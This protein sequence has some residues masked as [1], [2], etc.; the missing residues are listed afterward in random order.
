M[1]FFLI[2]SNFRLYP[3]FALVGKIRE[4]KLLQKF[5]KTMIMFVVSKIGSETHMGSA[6]NLVCF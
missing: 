3:T 5:F 1:L 6:L 4:K 2:S